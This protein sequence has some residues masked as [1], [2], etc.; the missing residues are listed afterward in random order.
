MDDRGFSLTL[1]TP[2][3]TTI[4]ETRAD[5]VFAKREGRIGRITLN[6]PKA[7]N[8]LTLEM[9]NALTVALEAWRD[10]AAVHLV[11]IESS[12]DRAFC[13]GGDVRSVR[14]WVLAD[15]LQDVET[16]FVLEYALNRITAY[17]P[18]PYVALVDGICM[19]G[20]IGLSIHGS[21]R[22]AT[23]HAV[24]AMPE[25]QLGLFPDVGGS[26]FLPRLR[27]RFGM[28]LGLTGTRVAAADACWLG[29][30]THYATRESIPALTA[31]LVNYGLGALSGY[32]VHPSASQLAAIED[33]VNRIFGQTSLSTIVSDL[34]ALTAPWAV[35]AL[36]AMRAASP[37]AL[38]WTFDLLTAGANLTFE[39]C[40]RAETLLTRR[41]CS[42]PDFAEGVR[43]NVVDKDRT[44]KWRS[45]DA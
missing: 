37:S 45:L 42:H 16:F 30:A 36:A 32:T 10:D 40:Q 9:I 43:A 39:E 7:L 25:T 17:Y 5:P 4:I 21:Y 13:A 6:R 27:G 33:D 11:V 14:D 35:A 1:C 23:E 44:P 20:G 26:Y 19:G 24:F 18:K 29:L 15:R 28:Y 34:E 31:D 3:L 2:S 8:A 12:S 41:A 22:V 38:H